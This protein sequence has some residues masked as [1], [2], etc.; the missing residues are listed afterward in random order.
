MALTTWSSFYDHILPEVN[1]VLPAVV[2][3]ELRQVAIDFC[4]QTGVHTAEVAPIDVVGGTA[5]YTLTSLVAGTEPYR[6][7]AAWY[8]NRPLDLAPIE[9]LNDYSQY[10]P[11]QTDV[12][13]RCYTQKQPDQIILFPQP[14]TSLSGG[15][16]VE[17]ILRPTQASTGLTD[18]I[19]NRYMRVICAGVKARLMSMSDRPWSR[20]DFAAAFAVEYVSGRGLAEIDANR[21]FIRSALSVRPHRF[22]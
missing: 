21:S 17:L 3:F 14:N 2:D 4:E 19:A 9:A 8:N 18:W 7:K 1:G 5:A 20:P 13:A 16:R 10:W 6:I 15:L 12:E 11:S 22:A